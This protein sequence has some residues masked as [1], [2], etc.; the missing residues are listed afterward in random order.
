MIDVEH[1]PSYAGFALIGALALPAVR[2]WLERDMVLHMLVQ[3]PLIVVGGMLCADATLRRVFKCADWNRLGL[4][5][6]IWAT[7]VVVIWMLPKSIDD[8]VA[9]P[10]IEAMKFLSLGIAGF[11]LRDALTRAPLPLEGFFLGNS[12]WMMAT[13]GLLYQSSERRLCNAYGLDSQ[14]ATGRGLVIFAL[15][16]AVVWVWRISSNAS[17]SLLQT[18]DRYP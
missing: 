2:N 12:V 4:T 5:G 1:I 9:K 16:I 8:A 18:L 10:I 3:L 13:V 14:V 15:T 7:M 17:V 6:F 11:L